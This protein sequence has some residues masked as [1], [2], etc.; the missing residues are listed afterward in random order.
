MGYYKVRGL[1][2]LARVIKKITA[3]V[4]LTKKTYQLKDKEVYRILQNFNTPNSLTEVKSDAVP[5]NSVIWTGWLQGED[6]APGVVKYCLNSI[7]KHNN[8]HL[9]VSINETNLKRYLPDFPK[10]IIEKYKRGDIIPA[11][12]MDIVRVKLLRTY[13]GVWVDATILIT[14][15]FPD[16]MFQQ[17]FYSH[18][19]IPDLYHA[20]PADYK[21][22]TFFFSATAQSDFINAIDNLLSNYWCFNNRAVD[23]FLLDYAMRYVYDNNNSI[24]AEVDSLECTDFNIGSLLPLLLLPYTKENLCRTKAF[25]SESPLFKLTYKGVNQFDNNVLS[26]LINE[27]KLV[28][29]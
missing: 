25:M 1:N 5:L 4:P 27:D 22:C 8:N 14:Q 17:K 7:R 23:Y 10:L 20:Y 3:N 26:A 21:W 19:G 9:V 11:H 24:K 12:F 29:Q 15:D 28:N 2:F 18:A 13:G 16:S 6:N